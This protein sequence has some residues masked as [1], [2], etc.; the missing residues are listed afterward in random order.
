MICWNATLAPA[1][2]MSTW[3]GPGR[4]PLSREELIHRVS[5][6]IPAGLPRADIEGSQWSRHFGEG[7][8]GRWISGKTSC[9]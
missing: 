2:T 1:A 7:F 5:R 4:M 8:G 9:R 6:A 3:S